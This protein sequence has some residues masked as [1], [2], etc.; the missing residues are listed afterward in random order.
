[1]PTL[2]DGTKCN[3][4]GAISRAPRV[5][6][7]V[8]PHCQEDG[9]PALRLS[10]SHE[11]SHNTPLD[12]Y[13]ALVVSLEFDVSLSAGEGYPRVAWGWGSEQEVSHTHRTPQKLH[14]KRDGCVCVLG[15]LDVPYLC[16]V[17]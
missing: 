5:R 10:V 17:G 2:I 9:R 1:M 16:D 7:T 14:W 13:I 3:E 12:I 8:F 11:R 6:C 15:Q 4:C